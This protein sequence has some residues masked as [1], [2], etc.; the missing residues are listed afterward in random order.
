VTTN[1]GLD[2]LLHML[3]SEAPI[4]ALPASRQVAPP[5]PRHSL[6]AREMEVLAGLVD[7][8]STKALA[9]RLG[10]TSATARTHVQNVLAKLGA[11]SRLQAVALVVEQSLL[12]FA[13]DHRLH[14]SDQVTATA[15]G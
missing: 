7:G 9:A 5:R 10:V 2:R 12:S 13:G 14:A 11:H 3:K 8:E 4:A 1:D 6:T 15:T